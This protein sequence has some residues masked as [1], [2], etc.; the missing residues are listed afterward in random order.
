MNW[1]FL[2]L[3]FFKVTQT[4][5]TK[6]KVLA[7]VPYLLVISGK[8]QKCSPSFRQVHLAWQCFLWMF[9][10]QLQTLDFLC[11]WK[12]K[13]H[14]ARVPSNVKEK[15]TTYSELLR[16][17]FIW[18]LWRIAN[19]P[20]N[21]SLLQQIILADDWSKKLIPECTG[22]WLKSWKETHILST[23]PLVKTHSLFNEYQT[24]TSSM[25]V[26]LKNW[27]AEGLTNWVSYTTKKETL[28]EF[29]RPG[30]WSCYQWL[31]F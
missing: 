28:L 14:Q 7:G 19:K 31:S 13:G 18:A 23:I 9:W 15:F 21:L 29:L 3:A 26:F 5:T 20:A 22:M 16:K 11:S 10:S 6:P 30:E 12:N 2:I 17:K 4:S 24:N 25:T 1:P 27:L 8:V